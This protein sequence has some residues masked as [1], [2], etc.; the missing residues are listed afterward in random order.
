M[1]ESMYER[2]KTAAR[3]RSLVTCSELGNAGDLDVSTP[4]QM[5][6]LVHNLD[7]I[8]L[9]EIE[10]GRP[11]LPIVVIRADKQLPSGGLFK[12]A[13]KHGLMKDNDQVRFFSAE[14]RTTH[15]SWG[16]QE[17]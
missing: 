17:D 4:A 16:A 15:E 3:E 7:E 10:A 2:L 11:L 9:H 6:Q 14:L 1:N 5:D 8:A 12:F 13:K